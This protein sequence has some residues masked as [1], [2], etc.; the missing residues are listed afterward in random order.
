VLP[1]PEGDPQ[2]A[3]SNSSW[4]ECGD[5][6]VLEG[7]DERWQVREQGSRQCI[8]PSAAL[9]TKLDDRWCREDRSANNAPK[10][11]SAETMIRCSTVARSKLTSSSACCNPIAPNVDGIMTG[12]LQESSECR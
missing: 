12:L 1:L 6:T 3:H 2:Q 8:R 4:L 5:A 11:T 9:A 7:I 10:S